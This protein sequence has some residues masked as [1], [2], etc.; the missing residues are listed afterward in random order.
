MTV[1]LSKPGEFLTP[2]ADSW[3][4]RLIGDTVVDAGREWIVVGRHW[5]AHDDL[6]LRVSSNLG[7]L[8][9]WG[10]IPAQHGRTLL[11]EVLTLLRQRGEA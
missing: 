1:Y 6:H 11:F 7:L 9:T 5:D 8:D 2:V 10:P 4:D 3:A